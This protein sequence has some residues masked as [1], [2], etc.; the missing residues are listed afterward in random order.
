MIIGKRHENLLVVK[1]SFFAKIRSNSLQIKDVTLH[2]ASFMTVPSLSSLELDYQAKFSSL[3]QFEEASPPESLFVEDSSQV[4]DNGSISVK[5]ARRFREWNT[6]LD[7]KYE[8]RFEPEIFSKL[9]AL[10]KALFNSPTSSLL[11]KKLEEREKTESLCK[12]LS[13]FDDIVSRIINFSQEKKSEMYFAGVVQRS[14]NETLPFMMHIYTYSQEEQK[15]FAEHANA[16]QVK[17]IIR[18]CLKE[19]S[20]DIG[21]FCLS[22][23][24][25]IWWT[26]F[27]Q[28]TKEELVA[29]TAELKQILKIENRISIF[30]QH[31][32]KAFE[33]DL[34]TIKEKVDVLFEH[35]ADELE[36]RQIEQTDLRE[37][38]ALVLHVKETLKALHAVIELLE[39]IPGDWGEFSDF[40]ND[41]KILQCRLEKNE[42]SLA[43]E[44]SL[45]QMVY[46]RVFHL[47]KTTLESSVG[48]ILLF[49]EISDTEYEGGQGIL[50][51][52][53]NKGLKTIADLKKN[54]ILNSQMLKEYLAH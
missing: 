17:Q 34:A 38:E 29:F 20:E 13:H 42:C 30:I 12:E 48:T 11:L 43:A 32:K 54:Q 47:D 36:S 33:A 14:V 51:K 23:P 7:E 53:K 25:R 39:G 46:N 41:Y 35:L 5:L 31:Q 16:L 26:L 22:V 49:W 44:H 37:I 19:H 10:A 2:G 3:L 6:L 24:E 21:F 8:K 1:N 50:E 4:Q 40:K 18:E 15:A 28:L 9:E 45:Y 52:L 27:N